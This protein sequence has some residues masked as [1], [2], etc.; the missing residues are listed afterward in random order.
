MAPT[1][2]LPESS[3]PKF[4]A[5][6]SASPP[7]PLERDAIGWPASGAGPAWF[8]TT[9]RAG[10]LSNDYR[11]MYWLV[12]AGFGRKLD[13]MEAVRKSPNFA[14]SRRQRGMCPCM[15]PTVTATITM[16]LLQRPN[17]GG[18]TLLREEERS[19]RE[20]QLDDDAD[21]QIAY[22]SPRKVAIKSGR[23]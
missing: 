20:G 5:R 9:S 10:R 17:A 15:P 2:S 21:Y 3:Q 23:A 22:R 4:A 7:S 13:T 18:R 16:H 6:V 8:C 11:Y 1:A 12:T 14:L 19:Q